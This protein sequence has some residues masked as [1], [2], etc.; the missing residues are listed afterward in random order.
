M[1]QSKMTANAAS[2]QSG[3]D[4][5]TGARDL[6][7]FERRSYSGDQTEQ[8]AFERMVNLGKQVASHLRAEEPGV[9]AVI[10]GHV[11]WVS[12][13]F[14]AAEPLVSALGTDLAHTEFTYAFFPSHSDDLTAEELNDIA[15]AI[16]LWLDNRE[17]RKIDQTLL[18]KALPVI[19]ERWTDDDCRYLP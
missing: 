7:Q 3:I 14:S 13:L 6:S 17:F 10:A 18:D 4:T 2:G 1:E 16:Q 15:D 11:C 19:I 9:V 8:V 12:P 5:L